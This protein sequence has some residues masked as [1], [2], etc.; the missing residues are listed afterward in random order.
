MLFFRGWHHACYPWHVGCSLVVSPMICCTR[1][2]LVLCPDI[3]CPSIK[4]KES[5]WTIPA[6]QWDVR[7]DTHAVAVSLSSKWCQVTWPPIC[8]TVLCFGKFPFWRVFRM[9]EFVICP[10]KTVVLAN[11]VWAPMVQGYRHAYVWYYSICLV[12]LHPW[13]LA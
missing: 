2:M 3:S 9:C 8:Q 4:A 13:N 7:N 11:K 6:E 12:E 10:F 5:W 1:G